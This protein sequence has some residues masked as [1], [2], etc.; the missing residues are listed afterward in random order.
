MQV[1]L[2]LDALQRVVDGLAVAA[3]FVGD[4]LVAETL[5]VQAQHAALELRQHLRAAPGEAV[6]LFRADHLVDRVMSAR[7]G[8]YV[9]QRAV[10]VVRGVV[11][12]LAEREIAV[13]RDVL[14]LLYTSP[15]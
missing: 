4:A 3:E 10:A 7:P 13:E 12:R 8:Q 5:Q 1:D 15:S 11:G 6:D 14:C 9:A 2:A